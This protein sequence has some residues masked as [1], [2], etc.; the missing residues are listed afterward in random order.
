MKE[1]EVKILDI[2]VAAV[3]RKLK[4]IGARRFFK[5]DVHAIYFDTPSQ[6]LTKAGK[7]LRVRTACKRIELC[8][9]S[10]RKIS[11]FK[12]ADEF[13]VLTSHFD[14]TLSLLATLG[15]VKQRETTRVRECYTLGVIKFDL[16][17]YTHLPPYIEVEGKTE[18]DVVSGVHKIGYTMEQTTSMTVA[19]VERHYAQKKNNDKRKK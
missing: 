19:E 13:E 4:N 9:K 6:E 15:F 2:D 5:G 12:E 14:D 10:N 7:E 3:R 16:D 17:S 11:R 8:V 1:I 18:A